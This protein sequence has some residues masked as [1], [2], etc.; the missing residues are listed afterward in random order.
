MEGI[1]NTLADVRRRDDHDLGTDR[2]NTI[3]MKEFMMT[4][5][6]IDDNAPDIYRY[7]MEFDTSIKCM[8]AGN[9]GERPRAID[10]H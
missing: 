7:D 5:P 4:K 3:S 9:P 8:G 6:T 10:I 2:F 1:A